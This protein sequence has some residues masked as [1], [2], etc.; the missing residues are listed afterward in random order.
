MHKL[1]LDYLYTPVHGDVELEK[2][3]LRA[4]AMLPEQVAH[5]INASGN[6][7]MPTMPAPSISGEKAT[8]L[9]QLCKSFL[10]SKDISTPTKV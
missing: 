3:V 4:P 7:N 10:R 1:N 5:A 2:I 9:R 6:A 8:A